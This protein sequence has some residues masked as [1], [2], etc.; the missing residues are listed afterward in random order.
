MKQF[1]Q[2][3]LDLLSAYC[4]SLGLEVNP[5]KSKIVVFRKRGHVK[6][7]EK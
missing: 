3:S 7:S 1:L 2:N 4:K 6:S 5:A